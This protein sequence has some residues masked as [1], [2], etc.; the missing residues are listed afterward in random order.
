MINYSLV[1]YC[2]RNRNDDDCKACAQ[3]HAESPQPNEP[4]E[5]PRF[6]MGALAHKDVTQ[7]H[8]C[9]THAQKYHNTSKMQTKSTI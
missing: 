2:L 6:R 3:W 5:A 4:S 1:T 8:A 7:A 9:V